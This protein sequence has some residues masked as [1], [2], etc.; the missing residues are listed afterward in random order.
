MARNDPK[1]ESAL[2]LVVS[3]EGVHP[4]RVCECV[5]LGGGWG[6]GTGTGQVSR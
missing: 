1:W 3:K 5:P 2:A 6:M 4:K